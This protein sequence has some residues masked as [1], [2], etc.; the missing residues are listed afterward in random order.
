MFSLISRL[1]FPEHCYRCRAPGSSLCTSCSCT[2]ARSAPLPPH[3]FAVFDYGSTL[4]ARAIW[5]IKYHRHSELARALAYAAVPAV[6]V[7]L[8]QYTR[9][10][11]VPRTK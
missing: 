2:L 7:Y 1:F 10:V 9:P 4:V 5:E 8:R 11:L 6:M 3:T